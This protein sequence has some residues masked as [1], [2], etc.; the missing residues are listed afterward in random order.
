[1]TNRQNIGKA[2]KPVII[3][4]AA[5]YFLIDA[6]FFSLIK[7]LGIWLAKLPIF[8]RIG[9][10]VRSLSPYATLV[11]FI[12]PFVLLEPIKPVGAY[13]IA[14]GHVIDGVLLISIGEILKITIVERLFQVGRDKLMSIPAFARAYEYLMSLRS[15]LH[16]L[17]IWQAMLKR[18]RAVKG[19]VRR[20]SA[21]AK[22]WAASLK[23]G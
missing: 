12:I 9:S 23:A 14:S 17:P 19:A 8:D 5:L 16:S 10:W 2:L 4:F 13:L 11:L 15:Y 18:V 21:F 7:P 3:T 6:L 22:K 20:M 1:M